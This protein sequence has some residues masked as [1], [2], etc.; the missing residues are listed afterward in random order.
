MYSICSIEERILK[1]IEKEL[2]HLGK[3]IYLDIYGAKL[4]ICSNDEGIIE[5]V[6]E[7]YHFFEK[8]AE[9]SDS[10]VF[11]LF[12]FSKDGSHYDRITQFFLN[13]VESIPPYLIFIPK[14]KK[15][16]SIARPDLLSFYTGVFFTSEMVSQNY[17]TFMIIHGSG[18]SK[19]AEGLIFPAALRSGKTTLAL[20]FGQIGY[21]ISSD[22]VLL[23]HRESLKV[24]PYPRL[25]SLRRE[26]LYLV[27]GIY[28][29]YPKMK[30]AYT[31][32]E[33]RWYL[34]KTDQ[35]S[36][37]FTCKAV[38]FPRL[39]FGKPSLKRL[40]K[41]GAALEMMKHAFY[42]FTPSFKFKDHNLDFS[43]L[44]NFLKSID[45]YIFNHWEPKESI[46]LLQ[47]KILT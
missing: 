2:I 45:S 37:P 21:K 6:R 24:F 27:P 34:D 40:T 23:I 25:V 17:S 1:K 38:A 46:E 22:D 47:K 33:T 15:L 8:S 43:T 30:P 36:E 42:P 35:V 7:G 11:T 3:Q 41:S 20:S 29:D 31:F 39:S 5:R 18:V 16:Y 28:K 44:T 26:S 32:G 12:A 14:Y 19:N 10:T 9:S 4:L 13:Q